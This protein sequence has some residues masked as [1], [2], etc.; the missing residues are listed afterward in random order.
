MPDVLFH[1]QGGDQTQTVVAALALG[2]WA[3]GFSFPPQK[4]EKIYK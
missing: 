4:T 1:L 2:R 3:P